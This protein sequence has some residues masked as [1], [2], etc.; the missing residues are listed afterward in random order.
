MTRAPAAR[1]RAASESDADSMREIYAHYARATTASLEDAPPSRAAF[2]A[3][4]RAVDSASPACLGWFRC[5]CGGDSSGAE[6]GARFTIR[7]F[8]D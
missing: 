8:A 1:I 7:F 2:R 3:R 5:M 4:V 6:S